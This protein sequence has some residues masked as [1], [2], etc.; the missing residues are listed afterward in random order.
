MLSPGEFS[1]G[2]IGDATTDLTLALPRGRYEY[3][4]LITHASGSPY[5]I[6]LAGQHQFA[7]FECS[8]NDSWKGILIPNVTIEIDEDSIFDA[9]DMHSH[10][11]TLVRKDTQLFMITRTEAGFRRTNRIPLITG[12][13]PCR[14]N[15]TAGF[16]KWRIFLGEGTT[17]RELKRVEIGNTP[18]D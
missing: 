14:Q 6:F 13:L 17:K 9:E 10:A 5:A 15:M 1:V 12:L 16:T 7:G 18:A 8:G 4:I 11:G 3:P 2:C